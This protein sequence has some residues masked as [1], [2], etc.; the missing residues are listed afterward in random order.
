VVKNH[1]VSLLYIV[2]VLVHFIVQAVC[3]P[4]VITKTHVQSPDSVFG[5]CDGADWYWGRF[6]S[7]YIDN[8]SVS[9]PSH[10]ILVHLSNIDAV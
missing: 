4:P 7:E 3:H 10:F 6:L 1:N 8:I 5:I 2:T 9:F